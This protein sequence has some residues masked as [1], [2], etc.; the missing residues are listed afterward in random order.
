MTATKAS[1][2][3]ISLAEA[4]PEAA[5]QGFGLGTSPGR[6]GRV[7]LRRDLG[8]GAFGVNAFHQEV[9]GE[10]V[11]GEHD[12]LGPGANAHEELYLVI[13]GGCTFTVDEETV[14]APRGAA[15]FVPDPASKR[16]AVA[17]EDGT[18][19]VAVG[20]RSGEAFVLSPGE[21]MG[22]FY[23]LYRNGDYAGALAAC[24]QALETY[25][26]NALVLYNIAC[27]ET[28]LGRSEAAFEP[29]AEALDAWAPYKELAAGDDDLTALRDDPRFQ[30][31]IA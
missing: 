23:P 4:G 2:S 5:E 20:G 10:N 12:E 3:L 6:R 14:D 7:Y 1:Y 29:L 13:Q 8:I 31:L 9:A 18:T 15:L 26:H 21:A 11:I 28:L 17:T 30:Q 22:D 16:S 27:L 24:K 19:V 25:P